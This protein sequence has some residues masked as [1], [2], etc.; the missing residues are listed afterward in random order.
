MSSQCQGHYGH[1]LKIKLKWSINDQF[2]CCLQELRFNIK[3]ML[4]KE[5][6]NLNN[7]GGNTHNGICLSD[8]FIWFHASFE[9][10]SSQDISIPRILTHENRQRWS[11]KKE[12]DFYR[13]W[14]SKVFTL[15]T[16]TTTN[17][18]RARIE[19]VNVSN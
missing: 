13:L 18:D 2:D 6:S 11:K 8:I 9:S 5:Y 17:L 12:E 7:R 14:N 1:F 15:N 19:I 10:T 3:N 4:N 16:L